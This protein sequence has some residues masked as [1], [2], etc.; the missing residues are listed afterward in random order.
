MFASMDATGLPGNWMR[1][2]SR[3]NNATIAWWKSP[4]SAARTQLPTRG[5]PTGRR[6]LGQLAR[7]AN[8]AHDTLFARHPMDYYWSVEQSEWAS[9]NTFRDQPIW[10]ASIRNWCI[11]ASAPLLRRCL[12][13]SRSQGG[14]HFGNPF[15]QRPVAKESGQVLY[16]WQQHQNVRQTG[17]DL[18]YRIHAQQRE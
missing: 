16:Q 17:P 9:D 7:H 6:S 10:P 3:T 12:A 8:P 2:A 5:A 18:A 14:G 4:T 11:T 15:Q 13:A 1:K